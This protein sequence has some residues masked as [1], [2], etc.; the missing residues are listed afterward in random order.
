MLAEMGPETQT[1]ATGGLAKLIAG[2]SKYIGAVDE[3]LTLTG[4]RIVYERNLERQEKQRRR[5]F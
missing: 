3:M 5:G 4:L 2:G 1:V